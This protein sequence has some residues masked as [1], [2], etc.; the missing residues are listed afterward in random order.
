MSSRQ[1]RGRRQER[2]ELR[3]FKHDLNKNCKASLTRTEWRRVKDGLNIIFVDNPDNGMMEMLFKHVYNGSGDLN[4]GELHYGAF[5]LHKKDDIENMAA[6]VGSV[7]TDF[8]MVLESPRNKTR[9]PSITV[10]VYGNK[11]IEQAKLFDG[12]FKQNSIMGRIKNSSYKEF[13]TFRLL[14]LTPDPDML[15]DLRSRDPMILR[16]G[17]DKFT[18]EIDDGTG[19]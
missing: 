4:K 8:P 13:T 11:T 3:V 15:L 9:E 16:F 10:K 17:L 12:L 2:P 18:Y 6:L 1:S 19:Q 5:V 7:K 14:T